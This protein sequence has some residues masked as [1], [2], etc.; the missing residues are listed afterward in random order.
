MKRYR[1]L[2]LIGVLVGGM[3]FAD[4]VNDMDNVIVPGCGPGLVEISGD[5]D[6]VRIPFEFF[7]ENLLLRGEMNGQ[8]VKFLIDNGHLWDQVWFYNGEID[9]LGIKYLND[10]E[11]TVAGIGEDGGSAIREGEDVEIRL[12][13][14]LF[15]EQPCLIS[16]PEAG[17]GDYFPG[18]AGQVS[19]LLFKHFVVKFDFVEK[20]MVLTRPEKFVYS[21]KGYGLPMS[22]L[23]DGAYSV[24]FVLKTAEDNILKIDLEIDLGTVYNFYL[25]E[26]EKEQIY[27]PLGAEKKLIG[28]GASGAIYGYEGMLKEVK[29]GEYVLNDIEAEFV[30]SG[31]NAD[32]GSMKLGTFG[33]PLMR[34]F[35]V[36]FDYFGRVMYFDKEDY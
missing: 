32:A 19:S 3:I 12:G 24:P 13:D 27:L 1:V 17:F 14:V 29:I 20:V 25:I 30:E 9:S 5:L 8:E 21:G 6:E 35:N 26:N 22:P 34:R 18:M 2:I 15:K 23:G 31:A 7:G 36:T 16:P 4:E 10:E 33:L 11:H 28:Y